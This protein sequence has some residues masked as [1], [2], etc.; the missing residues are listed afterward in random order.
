MQ[1][2]ILILFFFF[3]RESLPRLDNYRISK[4]NIKRP[5]ISQLQCE[6][7]QDE[8]TI[9]YEYNHLHANIHI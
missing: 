8:V 3:C 5:S 4:R 1:F 2:L 7:A 9:L 6:A